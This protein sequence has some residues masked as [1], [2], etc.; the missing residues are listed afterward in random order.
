MRSLIVHGGAWQIPDAEVEAHTRGV[1][2]AI[3]R[4]LRWLCEGRSPLEVVVETVACLEDDPTFDAGLGS[5]LNQDGVIEMDASLMEGTSLRAGS[6]VCVSGVR[7]P[8]RLARAILE[9]GRAVML[10]GG[11][12]ERFARAHGIEVCSWEALIVERERLRKADLDRLQTYRTHQPFDG[13]LEWPPIPG[14][15]GTV[16]AV[17]CD[18]AGRLAA[19]T[20]TGGAPNTLPGR[21]GDSPVLGA[22]TWAE[23]G[24]G[25]ASVTGWG[26]AILREVLAF[27]AVQAIDAITIDLRE[28]GDRKPSTG[29]WP[30]TWGPV[31]AGVSETPAGKAARAAI[32]D[33]GLRT[34][35]AAGV[36]LLGPDGTPGFAFSTPRMARAWWIEGMGE[37]VVEIEPSPARRQRR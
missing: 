21:I 30:I 27:R 34:G 31:P 8:I 9:D 23:D 25:A 32:R 22:G 12:A 18:A 26:E 5:V 37:P 13:T 28:A 10:A 11:G 36:I 14:P 6:C 33:L 7:N 3:A 19:A 29:R 24:V 17:C 35:G 4:G 2:E 1:R 15:S 16:G 20:S